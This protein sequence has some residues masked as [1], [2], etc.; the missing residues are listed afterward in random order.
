MSL[1]NLLNLLQVKYIENKVLR[2]ATNL[3]PNIGGS[4]DILISAIFL[5]EI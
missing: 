4:L 2:A 5:K 1:N 3:I